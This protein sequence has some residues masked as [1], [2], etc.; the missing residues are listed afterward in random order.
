VSNVTSGGL[1]RHLGPLHL[2]LGSNHLMVVFRWSLYWKL[3][4]NL[5]FLILWMICWS[6][7]FKS[8]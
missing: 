1:L 7:R 2:A 6:F 5:S 8:Y 3:G 4:Y